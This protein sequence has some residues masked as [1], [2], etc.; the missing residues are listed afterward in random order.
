VERLIVVGRCGCEG[1]SE[2]GGLFLSREC[3]A[4]V[5]RFVELGRPPGQAQVILW[6]V[7]HV[8]C[9]EHDIHYFSVAT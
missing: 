7:A 2:K 1:I 9:D 4:F 6:K 3:A 5:F 8:S